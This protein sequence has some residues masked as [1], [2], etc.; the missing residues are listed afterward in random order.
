MPKLSI[1]Y[2]FKGFHI[3]KFHHLSTLKQDSN[4]INKSTST[5]QVINSYSMRYLQPWLMVLVDFEFT[6]LIIYEVTILAKRQNLCPHTLCMNTLTFYKYLFGSYLPL[7]Q[8]SVALCFT[9]IMQVVIQVYHVPNKIWIENNLAHKGC[10]TLN[11]YL[12]LLS[13]NPKN[14][15]LQNTL[16]IIMN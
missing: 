13:L 5:T 11:N 14:N 12:C 15:S 10:I 7:S 2:K 4:L 8:K 6:F 3:I 16:K 9:P 1:M